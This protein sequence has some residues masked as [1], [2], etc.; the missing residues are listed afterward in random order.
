MLRIRIHIPPL[1]FVHVFKVTL[2]DMLVFEHP[3]ANATL[4]GLDV[5]NTMNRWQV[6]FHIAFLCKLLPANLTPKSCLISW[7]L[8]MRRVVMGTDRWLVAEH[9]VTDLTL[10]SRCPNL[11][12]KEKLRLERDLWRIFTWRLQLCAWTATLIGKNDRC[13]QEPNSDAGAVLMHIL[14]RT[15]PSSEAT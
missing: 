12:Q 15:E 3:R 11:E 4:K 14:V 13:Q 7:S 2:Q 1:D 9:Q 5:T 8:S 10:Y 6:P